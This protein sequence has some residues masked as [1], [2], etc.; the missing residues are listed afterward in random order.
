M[1]D[2]R[3]A[4]EAPGLG[5]QDSDSTNDTSGGSPL[6]KMACRSLRAWTSFSRSIGRPDRL[7]IGVQRPDVVVGLQRPG[8][9]L[10]SWR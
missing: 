6:V 3:S 9:H 2:E 10:S 1:D 4:V 7:G 5:R 8:E